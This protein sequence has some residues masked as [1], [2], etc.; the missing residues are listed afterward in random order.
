ML[1]VFKFEYFH[2]FI[3]NGK[4]FREFF[5]NSAL[6]RQ[7]NTITSLGEIAGTFAEH[8]AYILRNPHKKNKPQKDRKRKKEYYLPY[9]KLFT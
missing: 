4:F 1:E 2:K 8:Y 5:S 6:K 7:G 3:Y 9:N